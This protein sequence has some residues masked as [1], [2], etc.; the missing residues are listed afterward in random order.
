M[1]L[2]LSLFSLQI[3]ILFIISTFLIKIIKI[4]NRNFNSYH[5]KNSKIIFK[6]LFKIIVCINVIVFNNNINR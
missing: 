3:Q 2:N 6:Y 5:E 4:F 1:S